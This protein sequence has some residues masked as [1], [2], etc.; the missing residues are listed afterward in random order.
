MTM[1]L[2][3]LIHPTSMAIVMPGSISA[4]TRTSGWPMTSIPEESLPRVDIANREPSPSPRMK[5]MRVMSGEMLNARILVRRRAVAFT[6]LGLP[7][8]VTA[9]T[10]GVTEPVSSAVQIVWSRVIWG[11]TIAVPLASFRAV[12]APVHHHH[13]PVLR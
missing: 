11:R 12:R 5:A 10:T 2:V 3:W 8:R 13:R 6:G 4:T 9:W 7:A 1:S